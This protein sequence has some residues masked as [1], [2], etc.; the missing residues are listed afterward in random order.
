MVLALRQFDI[1]DVRFSSYPVKNTSLNN[2]S[3]VRPYKPGLNQTQNHR[4]TH[5]RGPAAAEP[6]PL[7]NRAPSTDARLD[8]YGASGLC[9]YIRHAYGLARVLPVF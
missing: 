9:G 1:E 8:L 7:S 5:S 2:S 4:S 3:D 6:Q